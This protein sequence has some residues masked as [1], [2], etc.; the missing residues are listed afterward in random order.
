M[1]RTR[2]HGEPANTCILLLIMQA[3]LQIIIGALAHLKYRIRSFTLLLQTERQSP[4]PYCCWERLL[5][6]PYTLSVP[7]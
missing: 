1:G 4:K 2:V 5:S 6:P 3:M 7:L